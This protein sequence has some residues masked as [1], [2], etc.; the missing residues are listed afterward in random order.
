MEH[1]AGLLASTT[2]SLVV[3]AR[4]LEPDWF[5]DVFAGLVRRRAFGART[6]VLRAPAW[7]DLRRI[8]SLLR[9]RSLGIA[10]IVAPDWALLGSAPTL[11][12]N[13]IF[14]LSLYRTSWARWASLER[15]M[16]ALGDGACAETL[17]YLARHGVLHKAHGRIRLAR[18]VLQHR[19][20]TSRWT[21]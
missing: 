21:D 17:G 19:Y 8:D 16:E 5:A 14:R 10:A 11:T 1:L 13:A 7:S 4:Y 2:H 20:W 3:N 6:L 15:S 12:S 9:E 18:S